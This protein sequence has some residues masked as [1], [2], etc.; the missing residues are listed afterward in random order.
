MGLFRDVRADLAACRAD[1]ARRARE[2][3]EAKQRAAQAK[4]EREREAARLAGA[5]KN[6]SWWER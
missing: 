2:E 3:R 4:R 1:D 6:L 5:V